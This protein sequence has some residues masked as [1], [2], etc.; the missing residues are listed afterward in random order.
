MNATLVTSPVARAV[1]PDRSV[2]MDATVGPVAIQLPT[3]SRLAVERA[4]LHHMTLLAVARRDSALVFH[5]AEFVHAGAVA[6]ATAGE[7]AT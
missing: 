5:G 7:S 6:S 3:D 2:L 4:V 1:E